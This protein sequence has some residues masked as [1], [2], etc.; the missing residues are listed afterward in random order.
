VPQIKFKEDLISKFIPKIP[1]PLK[2]EI[3]RKI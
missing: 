1:D 2:G 3:T